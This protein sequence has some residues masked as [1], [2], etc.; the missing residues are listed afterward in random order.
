MLKWKSRKLGNIESLKGDKYKKFY[1]MSTPKAQIELG[2]DGSKATEGNGTLIPV[3]YV[4]GR[5]DW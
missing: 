3:E 2:G 1:G 4:Y 5:M